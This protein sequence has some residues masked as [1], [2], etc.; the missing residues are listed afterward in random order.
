MIEPCPWQSALACALLLI[1]AS[2]AAAPTVAILDIGPAATQTQI[3]T[4]EYI[5]RRGRHTLEFEVLPPL[6]AFQSLSSGRSTVVGYIRPATLPRL[7][8]GVVLSVPVH[9]SR[10]GLYRAPMEEAP[11]G[12]VLLRG[13]SYSAGTMAFARDQGITYVNSNETALEM[14]R[15]GRQRHAV[16]DEFIIENSGAGQHLSK[17]RT[18][19]D[20]TLHFALRP[21]AGTPPAWFDAAICTLW[22]DGTLYTIHEAF[23]GGRE[24]FEATRAHVLAGD[25]DGDRTL[26]GDHAGAEH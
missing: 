5:A 6:R 2:A 11:A 23:Y 9:A 10:R 1:A 21:A 7:G 3:R 15:R 25:C 18:M 22:E 12:V 4:L 16:L 20:V 8:P 26:P 17:V 14:L 19:E 24:A 13:Y